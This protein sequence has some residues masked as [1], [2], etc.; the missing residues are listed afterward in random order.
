MKDDR[1]QGAVELTVTAAAEPLA[2]R[3]AALGW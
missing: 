3:L 1:V 2:D